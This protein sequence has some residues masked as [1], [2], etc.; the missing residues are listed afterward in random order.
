M[1]K[2]LIFIC[3]TILVFGCNN[4]SILVHNEQDLKNSIQNAK[5]GDEI[6]LA[7]GV[8]KDV[9]IKLSFEDY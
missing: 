1:Y 4:N 2:F 7:N 5:P 8:W 6:I 9:Q 3:L